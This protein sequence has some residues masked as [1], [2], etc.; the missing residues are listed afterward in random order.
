MTGI[1]QAIKNFL[2][3]L[4]KAGEALEKHK[5]DSEREKQMDHAYR[6][7]VMSER[8]KRLL[9]LQRN[10]GRKG[11]GNGGGKDT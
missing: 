3:L 11:K 6:S 2:A 5:E 7:G 1:F 10:K 4:L 9:S 8:L